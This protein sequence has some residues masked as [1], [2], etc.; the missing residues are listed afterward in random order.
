M[1]IAFIFPHL[2]GFHISNLWDLCDD[3]SFTFKE[4]ME[5]GYIYI[6]RGNF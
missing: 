1:S 4:N 2:I 5:I 3:G 6:M